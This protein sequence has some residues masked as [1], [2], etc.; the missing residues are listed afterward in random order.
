LNLQR[1]VRE[2]GEAKSLVKLLLKDSLSP[3][4]ARNS[5]KLLK[6]GEEK[7]TEVFRALVEA[8]HH[9]HIEYYIYDNDVIGNEIKEVLIRKAKEGVKVRL[10]YD[11][12][13]SPS[14]RSKFTRELINARVEAFPFNRI[15]FIV[16][17]NP[18][19][20]PNHRNIIVID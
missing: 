3:L 4:T 15:R 13:G 11:A 16:F 18:I 8:K 5:V 17:A 20:Y 1:D 6:N 14:I 2:I 10:I 9:I 7:F 19:N 12:F